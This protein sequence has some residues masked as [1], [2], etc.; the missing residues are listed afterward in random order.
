MG[1]EAWDNEEDR[2]SRAQVIC[3]VLRQREITA[4]KE[5]VYYCVCVSEDAGWGRDSDTVH[6]A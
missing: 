3:G 2:G 4:Q 5:S 1:R 6:I